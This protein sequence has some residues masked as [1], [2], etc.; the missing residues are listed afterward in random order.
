MAALLGC[1]KNGQNGR[2]IRLLALSSNTAT[3]PGLRQ[4]GI[5]VLPGN[6][7]KPKSLNRLAGLAHR[8]VHLAPPPTEGW[9]DPRTLALTRALARRQPPLSLIYGS[10]TGVYGDR[11]GALTSELAPHNPQTPRAQRRV[12]AE[13]AVN[14]FGLQTGCVV[15]TLRIPGIYAPDR[16]G[17]SVRE[18][19]LKKMPLL[20]AAEDVYT[21]HI[22]ADDLA[23]ACWLALW[24]GKPQRRYNI[25]DDSTVRMG[26]Y[27]DFL[28]DLNGLPRA[29]RIS[30][31]LAHEKIPM[32]LLSFM[33]E[34][35]RL[36][37]TR[38]K[39]E[40]GLILKFPT[41]KDGWSMPKL[42]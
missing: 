4:L 37:N 12:F 36:S 35:R 31:S 32:G 1:T 22:H 40:L 21:N 6:L 9:R 18:R 2:G 24:R 10:T 30:R 38:L 3:A 41:V 42:F 33:G 15:A 28:A 29:P 34:S 16:S 5:T 20:R 17:A 8:V 11:K 19:L 39:T 27:Y 26:D 7:D 14:Q 13:N 23:R 25:C